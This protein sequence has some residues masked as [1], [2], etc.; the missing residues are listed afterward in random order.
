MEFEL[1]NQSRHA[2]RTF[3]GKKIPT[4]TV[5]DIIMEATHAPSGINI[6]SW[7]FVILE[8]KEKLQRLLEE[9][10]PKNYPQLEQAG[11][12]I[13]IFSDKDMAQRAIEI[14]EIGKDEIS[15]LSYE[16]F[17]TRYPKM[18]SNFTDTYLNSYLSINTGLVTMNLM[19]VIKNRGYEGNILLGFNRTEK[20]N[21]ILEV[22][23]R[24]RPE[25]IIP[26]GTSEDTGKQ[27]YR[28][29]AEK[30]IEVR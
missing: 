22:D 7:H 9:V 1:L 21:E 19:Y 27:S 2:V 25:L 16:Q 11:A 15:E 3:D 10:K 12:I 14:G 28:L 20:V 18:I 6:Q 29:P 8:S 24:F 4:E 30:I 17:S 5:K 23:K 26:F 13:I